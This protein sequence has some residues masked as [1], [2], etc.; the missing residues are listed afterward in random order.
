MK[1]LCTE[2]EIPETGQILVVPGTVSE[3]QKDAQRYC[4]SEPRFLR[5]KLWSDESLNQ[6]SDADE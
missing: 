6:L 4:E 2:W 5:E 1:T 3:T